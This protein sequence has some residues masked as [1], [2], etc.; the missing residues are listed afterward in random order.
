MSDRLHEI[1]LTR[2]EIEGVNFRYASLDQ[3]TQRYDP[4]KLKEGYNQVHGEEVF[5][6]SNPAL[7]LWAYR[8]RFLS[9]A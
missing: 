8:G 1:A 2:E 9:D 4:A 7:G 6:V 5:Y 3:M